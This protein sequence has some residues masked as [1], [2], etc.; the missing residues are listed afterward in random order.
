MSERS[1]E[2]GYQSKKQKLVILS[3]KGLVLLL[4]MSNLYWL[5]WNDSTTIDKLA[6]VGGVLIW[7]YVYANLLHVKVEVQ[8]L[9]VPPFNIA[10][11]VEFLVIGAF[12]STIDTT[13]TI[14][15]ILRLHGIYL[16]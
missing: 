4:L 9:F 10:H 14:D 15:S 16:F 7:F 13:M 3:I 8:E 1:Y 12:F 5:G 6:H 11:A 2:F